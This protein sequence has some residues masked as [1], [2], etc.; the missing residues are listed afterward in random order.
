MMMV[1]RNAR[2]LAL[3]VMAVTACSAPATRQSG[4]EEVSVNRTPPPLPENAQTVDFDAT[5]DTGAQ[6]VNKPQDEQTPRNS[7]SMWGV[8]PGQPI[9][10]KWE[11]LMPEG[12]EEELERQEAE[13]YQMLEK[14][15]AADA[16]MLADANPFDQ[17]QEGSTLD[18]MP[19]LGTFDVVHDLDGQQIRIPG[20]VVPFDFNEQRRQ[21]EFLFVPYM[22]ACIHTPPPP[23]NQIIFVRAD[24]AIQLR[25]IWSPYWLEG[26]LSTEETH[27]ETGDA[28]YALSLAKLEP[29]E[30]R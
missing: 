17:I 11:D 25:D 12:A 23:P 2:A 21:G 14:R 9:P 30:Y 24:P 1:C 18:Y 26:T 6:A 13:F 4:P 10:I 22:G 29:Y 7:G 27:S 15:Y 5:T 19:Q 20:Y 28:A 8:E 3:L 16:T